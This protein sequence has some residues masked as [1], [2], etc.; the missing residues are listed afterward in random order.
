[1]NI[2]NSFKKSTFDNP[3]IVMVLTIMLPV[4]PLMATEKS[5]VIK[6]NNVFQDDSEIL[7]KQVRDELRKDIVKEAAGAASATQSV[8]KALDNNQPKQALAALEVVSGNLHV[9]LACD[10]SLGLLPIDYKI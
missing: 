2:Q 3:I 1:M 4:F 10:P 7:K 6:R 5:P 8:L 9:L